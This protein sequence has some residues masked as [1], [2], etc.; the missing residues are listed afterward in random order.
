[1]FSFELAQI[2]WAFVISAR[3]M[4]KLQGATLKV[5]IAFIQNYI[6]GYLKDTKFCLES[7]INSL[8]LSGS[9]KNAGCNVGKYL[10]NTMK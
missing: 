7:M 9:G 3:A 6:Y 8:L 2:T 1:M 4:V 5:R 10:G